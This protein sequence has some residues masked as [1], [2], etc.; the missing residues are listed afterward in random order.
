MSTPSAK[1]MVMVGE[2]FACVK[3]SGRANFTSSVDFKSV[4]TELQGKGYPYLVIELSECAL[5]DS[6]FLGVLEE[7]GLKA[8]P[9]EGDCEQSAIEL[10][11]ANERLT[12]LLENLGVLHLFK[13]AQGTVSALGAI[14]TSS[15]SPCNPSR[16]ELTRASLEAHQVLMNLN[17]EN[18]ARFKDVTK[19]LSEDLQKLQAKPQTDK[20]LEPPA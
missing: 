10:R 13:T 19:F 4:L 18:A 14:E 12:E 16:E 9:R 17:P 15:P 3:V 11:N 8:M 2:R 6:T 20:P 1:L 5:M 7:F